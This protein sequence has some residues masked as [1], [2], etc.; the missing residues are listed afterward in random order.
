MCQTHN[1]PDDLLVN[2]DYVP[3]TLF[4]S[5]TTTQLGGPTTVLQRESLI[6]VGHDSQTWA[7]HYATVPV[8][9]DLGAVRLRA[10]EKPLCLIFS[11]LFCEFRATLV[12]LAGATFAFH[13]L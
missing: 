12:I 9:V 5:P 11:G 13:F 6:W 10:S 7:P 3:G 2:T 4:S 8:F 1:V